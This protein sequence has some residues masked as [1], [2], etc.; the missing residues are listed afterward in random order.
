[1]NSRLLVGIPAARAKR[2]CA[3]L[4]DQNIVN[5]LVEYG[6]PVD[7]IFLSFSSCR[8]SFYPLHQLLQSY[9]A[10]FPLQQIVIIRAGIGQFNHIPVIN[11]SSV[12]LPLYLD[13]LL[14][15]RT[16]FQFF[17]T[18]DL[19]IIESAQQND[20]KQHDDACQYLNSLCHMFLYP[21]AKKL[22]R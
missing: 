11:R 4:A 2:I 16:P 1:M 17:V 8:F 14:P 13:N 10:I 20:Q 5:F 3:V 19:N 7:D 15:P 21:P 9:S 6:G 12:T 18:H 22:L